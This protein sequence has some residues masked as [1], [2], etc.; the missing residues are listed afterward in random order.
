VNR[1]PTAGVN[2]DDGAP[3]PVVEQIVEVMRDAH[4][5]DLS[6]F[7]EAFLAKSL[8]R[9]LD[10][11]RL[12][13]WAAYVDCLAHDRAEAEALC[14][15]LNISYSEFFRDPLAFAMLE[16]VLL[17]RLVQEKEQ[18]GSAALRVW[19]AGCAAGQE[20]WSI[21][22]LLE[23]HNAERERPVPFRIFATD[24]AEASLAQAAEGVYD[25]ATV[26][27]LRLKHL[28]KYFAVTGDACRI[29]PALKARVDFSAFDLLAVGASSPA[30]GIYG[31]FDLI[32][33]CNLLFYYRPEVR[34]RILDKICRA[35]RP[36]GY[37]VTSEAE[38][39]I[40]ARQTGLHA[41]APPVAVFQKRK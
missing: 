2:A 33:C 22:I 27:Q 8:Q 17:P 34:Q 32:L 19:S 5:R 10:G 41:V 16:Q 25:I 11:T 28:R 6:L 30:A 37:C 20:A 26:Q 4:G 18:S 36:G 21:A 15:S 3:A 12:E 13:T 1:L 14:Q 29:A 24:S 38:R 40:V 23:E 35:L 7:D 39:E 9:R 31:D